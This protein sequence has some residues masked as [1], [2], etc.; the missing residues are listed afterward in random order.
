MDSARVG[1]VEAR[2]IGRR[3]VARSQGLSR[4]MAILVTFT[5]LRDVNAIMDNAKLLRGT[6]FGISRDYLREISDARKQL[7]PE[8]K[9]ARDKYGA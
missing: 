5:D 7:W 2:R 3:L 6:Y 4:C 1:I 8:F 9:A